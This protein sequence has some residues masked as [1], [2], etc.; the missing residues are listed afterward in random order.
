MRP[1]FRES[2]KRNSIYLPWV[3]EWILEAY[4]YFN[5]LLS[6]YASGNGRIAFTFFLWAKKNIFEDSMAPDFWLHVM[7]HIL[8]KGPGDLKRYGTQEKTSLSGKDTYALW[9]MVGV[10]FDPLLLK[11]Q[12]RSFSLAVTEFSEGFRSNLWEQ[13]NH[14]F[15]DAKAL[16]TSLQLSLHHKSK[17]KHNPLCSA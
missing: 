7:C 12:N 2:R 9:L 10:H 13:K 1:L 4:T 16:G 8:R 6:S 17:Q 3:Y 5:F 15:R 11:Q 14:T